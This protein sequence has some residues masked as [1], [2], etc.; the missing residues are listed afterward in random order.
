MDNLEIGGLYRRIRCSTNICSM[1]GD[2]IQIHPDEIVTFVKFI[3]ETKDSEFWRILTTNGILGDYIRF[4]TK[5]ISY[6][7]KL[8]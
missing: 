8:C 1:N 6:W 5:K 2:L 7:E 3:Y 4:K